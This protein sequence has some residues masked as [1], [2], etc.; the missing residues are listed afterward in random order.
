[1]R[2]YLDTNILKFSIDNVTRMFPRK[3][4]FHLA[5]GNLLRFDQYDLRNINPND[6]INNRDLRAEV[7]LLPEIAAFARFG[8]V[9]FMMNIEVMSEFFGLPGSMEAKGFYH[10][11]ITYTDPPIE[12][13]RL[14]FGPNGESHDEMMTQFLEGIN[15]KRFLQLQRACGAFQG[16]Y[17]PNPNQ[18]KDA[19]HVWC[20][21]VA[22]ADYFLTCDLKLVRQISL[23]KQHAPKV[24]V[25]KPS[26]MLSLLQNE[27]RGHVESVYT[28]D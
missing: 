17:R 12:Y 21:E 4:T 25:V 24:K 1:M 28:C 18:L 16:Q 2:I 26:Q 8:T 11:P 5:N 13:Q 10:V 23:H 19:Y 22:N 7:N 3:R 6:R 20:A 27:H 14:I 15:H 9:E